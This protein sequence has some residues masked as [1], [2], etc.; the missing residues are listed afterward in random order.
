[1]QKALVIK[2]LRESAGIVA[3]AMIA[4]IY[5]LAELTATPIVPWQSRWIYAIPFVRDSIA[6]N[7]WLLGGG[8]AIAL[9]FRQTA[10]E[11]SHGTYFFLLH[12]PVSR[13]LVFG[14][15]LLVGLVLLMLVSGMLVVV[16]AWWAMTPGHFDA[17]FF[18]SM[19]IPTWQQWV[20]LPPIYFGAF[21]AGIRPGR[22]FGSRLVP[23]V[24]GILVA[25]VTSS[26]PWFWSSVILSLLGSGLGVLAI[27]YYVQSRDY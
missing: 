22:W 1:M 26:A 15:K 19:T 4:A 10:W 2:E 11:L 5:M 8:L 16:F 25:V 21:L 17:P 27:F 24:A 6:P 13:Q 18:W 20:A 7:L 9:G 14:L 12:R 3:L 23:L